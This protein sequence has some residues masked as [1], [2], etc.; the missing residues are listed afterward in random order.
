MI[1]ST[2]NSE[3]RRVSPRRLRFVGVVALIAAIGLGVLGILSRIHE[4]HA[5][6][7]KAD[8]DALP[9]VSLVDQHHDDSQ[10]ELIL[11]GNVQAFYDAPIYARV[12]GYLKKWYFDIGAT[13]KAGDV[14][15][16]IETPEI[17]QQLEQARADLATAQAKEKLAKLTA[18][19][20]DD[21]LASESVSKQETDEKN[22]DLEAKAAATTAAKANV[23]RLQALASFK[24]IVAPFDGVVTARKTDIGAL[25]NAGSSSGGELFRVADT[26]KLRIY[27]NVPQAYSDEIEKGMTAQ[28]RFP[29]KPGKSFPATIVSTS[30]S[31]N[32]SSRTM[33]VQLEADNAQGKLVSGS[34]AD[35]HFDLPAVQGVVQL[36]V[37]SLLFREHGLKVATLGPDNRVVLKNIQLGRDFGTRV[38]V[39]AGLDPTDRVIDSPP[40]W[41]AQGDSVRVA[42][43]PPEK[44]L[45]QKAVATARP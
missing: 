40:D 13:V 30:D 24:R 7:N 21:M 14:L 28:L 31:I 9:I 20:W 11:P 6:K 8:A 3:R 22:G 25:I 44:V 27:V 18:K 5:L 1:D 45:P 36:P 35:V 10:Q 39:T 19:R 16:E 12:P 17:D 23:D 38:E 37:T 41:L 15:A 42:P 26:R 32:E 29:E 34:Y 4:D 33:L 2:S 43:T